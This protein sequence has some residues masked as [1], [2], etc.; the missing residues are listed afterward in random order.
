MP[1]LF[2]IELVSCLTSYYLGDT[3]LA[4]E[5]MGEPGVDLFGPQLRHRAIVGFGGH[6]ELGGRG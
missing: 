6:R 4:R 1:N 3:N 5:G 2:I